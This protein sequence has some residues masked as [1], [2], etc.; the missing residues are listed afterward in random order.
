[1]VD[2][3]QTVIIEE[4]CKKSSDSS[5]VDEYKH[6]KATDPSRSLVQIP[7]WSMNTQACNYN[8]TSFNWFRFLYGRWIR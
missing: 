3:Y 6:Y 8:T 7:L 4:L 1:M 2:E 5:M